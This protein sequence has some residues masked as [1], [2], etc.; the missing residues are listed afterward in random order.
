MAIKGLEINWR[1]VLNFWPTMAKETG[2]E[3]RFD[4]ILVRVQK[5]K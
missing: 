4:Y 3:K 1:G 5:R 2:N